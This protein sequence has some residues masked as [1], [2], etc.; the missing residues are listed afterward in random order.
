MAAQI[1]PGLVEHVEDTADYG[2]V[3]NRT[4]SVNGGTVNDSVAA[5]A[6]IGGC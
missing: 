5:W 2:S 1:H 3:D 6:G 4:M